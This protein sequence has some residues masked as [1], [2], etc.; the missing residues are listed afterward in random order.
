[1]EIKNPTKYWTKKA[2]DHLI[3]RKI[4]AVEYLLDPELE[5]FMWHK[6]PLAMKLDDGHWIYPTMDDEGNDGGAMFTT[7]SDLPCIPVM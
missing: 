5:E 7:Y 6:S 1:M 4:V 2:A 3:G